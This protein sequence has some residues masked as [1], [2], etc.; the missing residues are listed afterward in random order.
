[1]I[2]PIS[3]RRFT[4]TV[5]GLAALAIWS[6]TV[7]IVR[8]VTESL[9]ATTGPALAM[10]AGG[11]VALGVAWLRG[12][13]PL[14]MLRLPRKYLLG[15]GGLFVAYELCFMAA[16]GWAPDRTTVLVVGLLN[17]LWTVMTVVLSVPILGRRARWPLAA[18]CVVAAAGTVLAAVGTLPFDWAQLRRSGAAV[19]AP[20]LLATVGA[21]LWGAYSNFTRRWGPRRG[22]DGAVPLFLLAAGIAL[23]LL[24]LTSAE[25]TEWTLKAGLELTVLAVAQSAVAY[26]L[27]DAGMRRGNHLLLSL[28]SYFLP[29]ASTLVAAVYLG[30]R[31]GAGLIAGC[32]LVTGGALIC[33]YSIVEGPEGACRHTRQGSP[34]P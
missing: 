24:R 14:S 6:T 3:D 27:W 13:S 12:R 28:A 32:V 23:G 1:V 8:G 25:R 16:V 17:Y 7:G 11:I 10:A 18:G 21:V 5:G 20:I 19:V 26:V 30:V 22:R 4:A 29:V 33:R 34:E 15:C 9:G 31:P 2:E